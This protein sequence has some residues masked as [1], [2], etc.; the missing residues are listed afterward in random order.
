MLVVD[1]GMS[2]LG[3]FT[4]GD[5]RRTVNEVAKAGTNDFSVFSKTMGELMNRSPRTITANEMAVDAIVRMENPRPI[6]CM[7]CVAEGSRVVVGILLLHDL[8]RSGL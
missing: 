4:D 5:M 7:P 8:V 1:E 2:L 6:Q 3:I